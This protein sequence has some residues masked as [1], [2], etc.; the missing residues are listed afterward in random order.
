MQRMKDEGRDIL[1]PMFK[2]SAGTDKDV[3]TMATETK[4]QIVMTK[5]GVSRKITMEEVKAHSSPEEPW[6]IVHGEVY[7]GTG[8]LMDH[9]GGV[10]EEFGF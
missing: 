6:F 10:S 4:P 3:G 1:Q 2:N 7:D 5:E 8:F 9:P